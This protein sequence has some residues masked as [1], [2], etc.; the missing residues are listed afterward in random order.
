MININPKI[1]WIN[2]IFNFF[3]FWARKAPATGS[4]AAAASGPRVAPAAG[5]TTAPPAHQA[6]TPVQ[7][8]GAA[9]ADLASHRKTDGQAQAADLL[10]LGKAAHPSQP[11]DLPASDNPR[12][13][14]D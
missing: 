7:E 3:D 2:I 10:P 14:T 5:A 9:R 11:A 6:S 4:T 1:F 12:T 8:S 13:A